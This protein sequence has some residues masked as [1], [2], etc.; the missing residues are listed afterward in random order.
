MNNLESF[1]ENETR[2][3]LWDFKIQTDHL[4]AA[5]RPDLVIINK[6][7]KTCRQVDLPVQEDHRLKMKKKRKK[8]EVLG[9]YQITKRKKLWNI[10]DTN[11]NW[12]A[13][14][15]PQKFDKGT[16]RVRIQRT[17]RDHPNYSILWISQNTKN[18]PGDLRRLAVSWNLVKDHQLALL[19]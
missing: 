11:R 14:N 5:Q 1:Q 10:G 16:R 15:G 6:K 19:W 8:T 18:S 13:W 17:N 2:R 7:Q 3:I 4:I 12:C 9:S